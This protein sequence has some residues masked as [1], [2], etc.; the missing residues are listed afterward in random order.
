MNAALAAA[1][2]LRFA[3]V[4]LAVACEKAGAVPGHWKPDASGEDAA[5]GRPEE[6]APGM[7]GWDTAAPHSLQAMSAAAAAAKS[8]ACSG[9]SAIWTVPSSASWDVAA[10]KC[11]GWMDPGCCPGCG[12]GTA[13][14]SGRATAAGG[15][16]LQAAA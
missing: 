2:L 10:A 12:S 16:G 4:D 14:D 11:Y 13:A 15:H 1:R 9:G 6:T 7:A 5:A 3:H 8:F